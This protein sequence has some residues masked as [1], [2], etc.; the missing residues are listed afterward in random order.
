M[1]KKLRTRGYLIVTERH[2]KSLILILINKNLS[3]SLE[4][5]FFYLRKV[6]NKNQ[7]VKAQVQK[8]SR[9]LIIILGLISIFIKISI[10]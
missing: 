2:G 5:F 9:S 8:I 7:M 6:S 10:L 3:E 4:T 1:S